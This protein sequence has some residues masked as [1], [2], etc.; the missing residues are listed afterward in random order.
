MKRAPRIYGAPVHW[1]SFGVSGRKGNAGDAGA[2]TRRGASERNAAEVRPDRSS[3]LLD[4]ALAE[5]GRGYSQPIHRAAKRGGVLRADAADGHQRQGNGLPDAPQFLPGDDGG[6][7]L[8]L[9]GKHGADA[10]IIR[11]SALR[12]QRLLHRGDGDAQQHAWAEDGGVKSRNRLIYTERF[13]H[14]GK[15]RFAPF[16]ILQRKT[17]H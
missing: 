16:F 4:V 7:W 8:G 9:R 14:Q 13:T 5:Y 10:Q 1:G 12:S 17:I 2:Q 3:G 6:I 11:A 15:V